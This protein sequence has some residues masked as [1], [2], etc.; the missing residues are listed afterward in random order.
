[1]NQSAQ[2]DANAYHVLLVS[3]ANYSAFL[4]TT[5]VSIL[6]NAAPEDRLVFHIV[7]SGLTQ[8]DRDSVEKLKEIR[9]FERI[10]YQPDLQKY[11]HVFCDDIQTFPVVV[12]H[13]LFAPSFLPESLDKIIYMDVDVVVLDSLRGLWN[14]DPGEAILAAVHD[15]NIRLSHRR[16]IGL[17]DDYKYFN[18]GVLVMNLKKW[19]EVNATDEMLKIAAEIKENIDFPD[20]DVLNVYCARHALTL[21]PK[22]W[23]VHPR[24]Y[25]EGETKLLHFMGS[26]QRCPHLDILYSYA[27]ETPYR[28]LPMQGLAYRI[29]RGV[30]RAF[31]NTLCFF[32]FPRKIRR[33]IRRRFNLR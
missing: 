11:L 4:A 32:F 29:N 1:M 12:N 9:D 8:A 19:R 2:L 31:C 23:N 21:A 25:R 15:P 22:E 28:A 27:A 16:A 13:R 7:D 33:A 18:S 30:Q 3:D 20:Q 17:D 6:K 24:D 5:I 10:F 26:R 14:V